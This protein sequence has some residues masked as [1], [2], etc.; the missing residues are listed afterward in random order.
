MCMALWGKWQDKSWGMEGLCCFQRGRGRAVSWP[1][2]L[3]A[4]NRWLQ[5]TLCSRTGFTGK[6]GFQQI[7]GKLV[8][9]HFALSSGAEKEV[10]WEPHTQLFSY[11]F[12][13]WCKEKWPMERWWAFRDDELSAKF[14]FCSGFIKVRVKF[15]LSCCAV[16]WIQNENTVDDT[17]KFQLLLSSAHSRQ[18]FFNVQC[19]A[20]EQ[21][22]KKP[23]ESIARRPTPDCP[24]GYSIPWNVMLRT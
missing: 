20:H 3:C 23:E 21:V 12:L 11:P 15:P 24:K 7:H 9:W 4:N 18:G 8:K 5:C 22:H 13:C 1:S 2:L 10:E 17:L 16:F 19:S 6:L 14:S